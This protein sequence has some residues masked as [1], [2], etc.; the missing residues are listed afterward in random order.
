MLSLGTTTAEVKSGYGLSLE[1]EL[2]QLRAIRIAADQHA[3]DVVHLETAL[4]S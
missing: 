1:A 3:V 4:Y 2:K